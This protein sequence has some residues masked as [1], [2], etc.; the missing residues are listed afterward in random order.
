MYLIRKGSNVIVNEDPPNPP[1]RQQ[2]PLGHAP[3]HQHWHLV[4]MGTQR[5]K[6]LSR[7]HHVSIYLVTDDGQS[8]ASCN[9]MYEH[10]IIVI[11]PVVKQS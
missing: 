3:H 4:G 9:Y 11:A 8:V 6:L 2:E 1:P 10:C 7:E 5:M